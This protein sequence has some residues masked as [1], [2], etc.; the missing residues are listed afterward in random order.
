[1]PLNE[2][3]GRGGRFDGVDLRGS[4]SGGVVV[5]TVAVGALISL[6]AVERK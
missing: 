2:P 5:V 1:M 4:A 6:L 3:V